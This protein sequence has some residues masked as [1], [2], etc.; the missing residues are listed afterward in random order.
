MRRTEQKVSSSVLFQALCFLWGLF[1]QHGN[2]PIPL[3]T[4]SP[5]I[6]ST[7]MKTALIVHGG[8]GKFGDD[9]QAPALEGCREAVI[10][11]RGLLDSGAP[12]LDVAEQ[13]VMLLEDNPI[14]DAGTGSFLNADGQVEMDAILIN[15]ETLCFGAVAGIQEVRNP[16]TVAR[17]VMEQTPHAFL[18]GEGATHFARSIDAERI[19]HESHATRAASGPGQGTVGVVALDAEGRIAVATSTGGTAKKMP[20]RVGDSPL[21][22]A[23]AIADSAVGGASATGVGEDLMKVQMA[24]TAWE[25][26]RDGASAMEAAQSSVQQL[27]KRV[28]GHGGVICVDR[29]GGIGWAHNTSHMARGT[30][31]CADAIE[32]AL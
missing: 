2:L 22:G 31:N 21:I 32:V 8:A 3:A 9:Q 1:L 17:A 24:R 25:F 26:M 10:R 14:F 20:G 5:S 19:D 27:E 16:I 30:F 11:G 13:V 28:S 15:G 18:V 12:A 4:P 29:N 23:G 6:Y 7:A